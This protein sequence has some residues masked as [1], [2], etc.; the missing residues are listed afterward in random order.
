MIIQIDAALLARVVDVA[1]HFYVQQVSKG[2]DRSAIHADVVECS[3]LL[4][5]YQMQ[6]DN[7]GE[8]DI[9]DDQAI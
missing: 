1:A 8:E 9:I 5:E 2:L 6:I 4:R 7:I 3:L